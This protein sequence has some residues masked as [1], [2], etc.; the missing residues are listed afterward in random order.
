MET[1]H[2]DIIQYLMN[3]MNPREWYIFSL[4]YKKCH[5]ISLKFMNARKKA[6]MKI[7]SENNEIGLCFRPLMKL[8]K[9]GHECDG[10]VTKRLCVKHRE[11][12]NICITC[13]KI[14]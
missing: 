5:I 8:N 7:L 6:V 3:F 4:L 10:E 11:N 14:W 12:K 9:K 13:K 2:P 1:I